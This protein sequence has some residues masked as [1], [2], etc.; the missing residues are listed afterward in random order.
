MQFTAP[1]L[2]GGA[3]ASF[4]QSHKIIHTGRLQALTMSGSDVLYISQLETQVAPT[5][6]NRLTLGGLVSKLGD[7]SPIPAKARFNQKSAV[8]S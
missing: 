6:T 4:Y 8:P 3:E 7:D 1:L 2:Q 5:K